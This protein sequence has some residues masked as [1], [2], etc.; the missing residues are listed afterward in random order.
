[1]PVFSW[2]LLELHLFREIGFMTVLET[3]WVT[4]TLTKQG[5]EVL[6][7]SSMV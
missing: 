3:V 7:Q 6:V 1:M 4:L 5:T 2:L